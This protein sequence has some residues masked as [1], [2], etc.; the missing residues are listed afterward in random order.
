M[1]IDELAVSIQADLLALRHDMNEGF[2]EI[3]A[4]M[5]TKQDLADFRSEMNE[6]FVTHTEF[7][8]GLDKLKEE[9]L[10]EIDKIKYAKEIDELRTRMG[11]VE[12]ELGMGSGPARA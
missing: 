12:Y 4:V 3:H 11:R 10:A 1:T 2:A 8:S 9:L 5:V 7:Q 6:R